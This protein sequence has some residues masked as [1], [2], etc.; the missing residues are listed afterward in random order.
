MAKAGYNAND[1]N[2]GILPGPSG[3]N[4]NLSEA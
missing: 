1:S 2:S 4:E 3:D